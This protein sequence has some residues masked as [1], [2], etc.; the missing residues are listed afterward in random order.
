MELPRNQELGRRIDVLDCE[1]TCK[2]QGDSREVMASLTFPMSLV[3]PNLKMEESR[4]A[5]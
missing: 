2:A 4:V 3:F 1:I 5:C